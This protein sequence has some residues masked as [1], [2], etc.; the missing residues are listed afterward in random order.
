[1]ISNKKKIFFKGSYFP[2]GDKSISHR[3]IILGSQAV[4]KSIVTN[5][6]EGEDVLN[7]IKVMCE[8]GAN[9]KK[10]DNKFIIYGL[11]P[12][13][14]FQPKKKLDFGNSGTGIRLI[15]GLVSSNN[16]KTVLI[17]DKSL[18]SRPMKRVTEHLSRIGSII[19]LK[20]NFYPP[21]NI[22]GVGNAIPLNFEIKIPSAQIKS[23]IILSSLNTNGLVKIKEF[24]STRDHTENMLK[25]MGYNIKVKHDENYRYI[26]LKN[27]R[28][29]KP[30]K[31]QVP[32]DPSSAAFLITGACLLP[33][34]K[35]LVK[36][37]LFNKTRI[38]FIETL[39]S[40]GGNIKVIKK[41]KLNNETVA[42]IFIDQKRNLKSVLVKSS[43]IP[44]QIDEVP[45]LSIAA[46][47]ANGISIFKGLKELTVK[48]SNRL[49]LIHKNL[50]KM[51]VKSEVKGFDLYIH[52]NNKLKKGN[53]NII[54]NHDHRIVMAFYVA[55]LICEKRNIIKDK[56]C[57]NTSYPSF[58][59]DITKF[60]N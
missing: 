55:N 58:F 48:E 9:I 54:H 19:K 34:S 51:G 12:G 32:G 39:K 27:D 38:G 4:G 5:L 20:N 18:N 42:D 26:E 41:E 16:I 49:D 56:S 3:I 31:Y 35:L 23:S 11:P 30:I 37:I 53:A 50:L 59:K 47:F 1:M 22:K 6:L 2:P 24:R 13:S 60:L 7:T 46:S 43:K 10:R 28:L 25:S 15:A 40:M 17:G 57:V 8:L 45:I 21:I 14:L 33:G 44:L 36:N 29:L 52:G